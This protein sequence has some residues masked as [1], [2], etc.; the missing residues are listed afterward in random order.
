MLLKLLSLLVMVELDY[1][2]YVYI[3]QYLTVLYFL[4]GHVC[5]NVSGF[6]GRVAAR[7]LG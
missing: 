5:H 1:L 2:Y 3:Q 6:P 7:Q 4:C